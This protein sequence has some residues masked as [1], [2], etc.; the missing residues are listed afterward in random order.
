M[1]AH[2]VPGRQRNEKPVASMKT[3]AACFRRAFSPDPRPILVAPGPDHFLI[4]LFGA[5]GRDLGGSHPKPGAERPGNWDGTRHRTG[6]GSDHESVA[7][8]S[9]RSRNRP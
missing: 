7:G 2:V 5:N 9:D 4:S 6:A 8:S 3:M 1:G